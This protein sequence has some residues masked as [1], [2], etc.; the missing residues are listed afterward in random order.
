MPQF[1][2][3]AAIMRRIFRLNQ[4]AVQAIREANFTVA[5]MKVNQ[6]DKLAPYAM[7]Q[8]PDERKHG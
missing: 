6:M 2:E 4:D 5:Q 8:E 3:N 1:K 7:E